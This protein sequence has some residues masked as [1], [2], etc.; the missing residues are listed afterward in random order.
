[1]EISIKKIFSLY[2]K[3]AVPEHIIKHMAKVAEYS[4]NLCE[5]FEK[6]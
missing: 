5:K 2:K 1:M 6:K 3:Y 4:L